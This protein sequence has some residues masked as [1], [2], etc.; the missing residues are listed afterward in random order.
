MFDLEGLPDANAFDAFCTEH[1]E[2]LAELVLQQVRM[3][4]HLARE[5]YLKTL[6]EILRMDNEKYMQQLSNEIFHKDFHI[7]VER[8]GSQY[9]GPSVDEMQRMRNDLTPE[10]DEHA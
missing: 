5:R 3:A 2:T 4:I 8:A 6:G 1:K 9:P 10:A 7:G